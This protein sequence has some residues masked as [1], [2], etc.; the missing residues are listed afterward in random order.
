MLNSSLSNGTTTTRSDSVCRGLSDSKNGHSNAKG[1]PFFNTRRISRDDGKQEMAAIPSY[2]SKLPER[3]TDVAE[4][5]HSIH[6][7]GCEAD[8]FVD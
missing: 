3:A 7:S 8:S 5:R 2:S 1:D 6:D 4:S